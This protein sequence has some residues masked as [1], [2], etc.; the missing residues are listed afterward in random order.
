[1]RDYSPSVVLEVPILEPRHL[2]QKGSVEPIKGGVVALVDL[3]WL[4]DSSFLEI[5]EAPHGGIVYLLLSG[6]PVLF[7][8]GLQ[9]TQGHEPPS[10]Y[11]VRFLHRRSRRGIQK[12]SGKLWRKQSMRVL[13]V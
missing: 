5:N 10:P 12:I 1:M 11:L 7:I 4:L 9:A 2:F 3:G 8:D 6:N 13:R